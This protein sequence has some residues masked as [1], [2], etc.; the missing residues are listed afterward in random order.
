MTAPETPSL[1]TYEDFRRPVLITEP[2]LIGLFRH[3]GDPFH[4]RGDV[5]WGEL[6]ET[7]KAAPPSTLVVVDPYAGARRGDRFP[8]VRELARRFPSVPV[9]ALLDLQREHASDVAMLLEWGVSEIVGL[10]PE[11]TSRALAHRL[12]EAHARPF[13]RAL[14]RGLTQY[15]NSDA[16]MVLMA[17]A[18]VTADGGQAPELGHMLRVSPRTL[19]DRCTSALLPPPRYVLSWMRVLLACMLLDDPGRTVYGAAR[20]SGYQT[21]RSL[22][23]AITALL[24]V[25]STTLRRNGAFATAAEAFNGVLRELREAHRRALREAREHSRALERM[26]RT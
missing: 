26:E 11:S 22:R 4:C 12:G 1:P 21:E 16:R 2:G 25:D 18:E 9:V 19:T 20:A 23:R 8:K 24:G 15:M 3:V 10:G 13:K 6:H 5:G 14:E 7:L 17:S